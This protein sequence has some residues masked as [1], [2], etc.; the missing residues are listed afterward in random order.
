[1]T[2]RVLEGKDREMKHNKSKRIGSSASSLKATRKSHRK[3]RPGKSHAKDRLRVVV[4]QPWNEPLDVS[5]EE[6]S[7]ARK[8]YVNVLLA[9]AFLVLLFAHTANAMMH[10][11]QATLKESLNI[12]KVG[13]GFVAIWAGGKAALKVFSG[14]HDRK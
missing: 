10:Q 4:G 5:V 6:T 1:M 7:S 13:L 12:T 3:D 11:D 9:V 2:A 8:D 14:W